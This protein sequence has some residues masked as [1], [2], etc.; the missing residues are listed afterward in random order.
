VG[1]YYETKGLVKTNRAD[2]TKSR[3]N[4]GFDEINREWPGKLAEICYD[5]GVQK[6]VHVSA[7]AADPN[8][9]SEWAKT[10]AAGESEVHKAFPDATIIRPG[11]LFG[12]EDRLLNWIAQMGSKIGGV[13]LVNGGS[14]LVQPVWVQDVAEAIVACIDNEWVDRRLRVEGKI[15][16]AAGPEE[17]TWRE[18][19]DFVNDIT[20]TDER[21]FNM[22]P[23]LAEVFGSVIERLPVFNTY[24]PHFCKE[25]AIQQQTDVV[26]GTAAAKALAEGKEAPLDLDYLGIQ[27]MRIEDAAFSYL[28]RYREGGHFARVKGYHGGG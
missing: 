1:K 28:Y 4:Y 16:E 17:Y 19:R 15:I 7:M 3:V 8:S 20:E 5:M 22:H 23:Q 2:G 25:D 13:P 12:E 10:K 24:G 6:L 11:K 14:G 18:L 21:V 27:P 9:R 26:A